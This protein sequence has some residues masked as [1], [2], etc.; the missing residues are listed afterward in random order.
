M[1]L[2]LLGGGEDAP[3]DGCAYDRVSRRRGHVAWREGAS[4]MR[5]RKGEAAISRGIDGQQ[6]GMRCA[7]VGGVPPP[8]AGCCCCFPTSSSHAERRG[9]DRIALC[10]LP[11]RVRSTSRPGEE[12]EG[13]CLA[14]SGP[15]HANVV[16]LLI[17]EQS[18]SL[19]TAASYPTPP[20]CSSPHLAVSLGDATEAHH[21][22]SRT[23]PSSHQSHPPAIAPTLHTNCFIHQ[24]L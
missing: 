23:F 2:L 14:S 24:S 16:L 11:R 4:G 9:G 7:R 19:V 20:S 15:S 10:L 12:G 6:Y 21:Q 17:Y 13:W 22:L 5:T 8:L 3:L 1:T 18:A